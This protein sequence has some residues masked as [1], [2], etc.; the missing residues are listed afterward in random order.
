MI[1]EAKEKDAR[2]LAK[3]ERKIWDND[4]L[5]ELEKEFVQIVR[6]KNSTCFI[7][8]VENKAIGFSNVSLRYDYVEGTETSPVAYLEGI[9]V[10]KEY[11][12]KGYGKDLLLACENWARK[13]NCKEFASD[14]LIGNIE[15]YKFHLSTGFVEANRIICYKKDL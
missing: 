14:S 10:N 1:L 2:L 6:D 11:R 7:K 8:I 15:S 9:F 4:N 3:M 5:D 12:K 13:M